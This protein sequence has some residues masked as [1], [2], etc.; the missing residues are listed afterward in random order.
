M[1]CFYFGAKVRQTVDK[2][3]K[4]ENPVKNPLKVWQEHRE[5]EEADKEA[6][7]LEVISENLESYDGTPCGQKDIPE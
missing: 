3:E 7:R 1:A 2:G 5:K 6:K 4:L